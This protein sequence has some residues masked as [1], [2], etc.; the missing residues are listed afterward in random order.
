M[1]P[2]GDPWSCRECLAAS[3]CH[4]KHSFMDSARLQEQSTSK[5]ASSQLSWCS[6]GLLSKSIC[7]QHRGSVLSCPGSSVVIAL[8]APCD[9]LRGSF[10]AQPCKSRI[11]IFE[12]VAGSALLSPFSSRGR[13]KGHAGTR[14]SVRVSG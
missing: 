9:A 11:N 8:R 1:Q 10:V 5:C 13:G 4:R 7:A 6:P 12:A 3:P 2:C 14:G